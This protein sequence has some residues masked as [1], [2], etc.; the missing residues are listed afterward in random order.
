M[1]N[2]PTLPLDL[3]H[4]VFCSKFFGKKYLNYVLILNVVLRYSKALTN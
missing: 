3:K 1:S 2:R 4:L